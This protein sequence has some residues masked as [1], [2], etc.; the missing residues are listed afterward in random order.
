MNAARG[1][2]PVFGFLDGRPGT[3][4]VVHVGEAIAAI[5]LEG[6]FDMAEAPELTELATRLLGSGRH[7]IIDLGGATFVD[8]AIVHVLFGAAATAREQGRS[9]VLQLGTA[10]G[11]ARTLAVTGADRDLATAATRERAIE[12]IEGAQPHRGIEGAA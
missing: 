10:S 4:A 6:E 3:I 9:F 2:Q 7:L 12:L 1:T 8:S 5:E 11:A